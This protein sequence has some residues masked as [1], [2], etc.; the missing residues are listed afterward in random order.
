MIGFALISNCKPLLAL[1]RLSGPFYLI[2][3]SSLVGNTLLMDAQGNEC[4]KNQSS[5]DNGARLRKNSKLNMQSLLVE[6]SCQTQCR[7]VLKYPMI[8]CSALFSLRI[9]NLE[10]I[11]S[12]KSS[13]YIF[14]MMALCIT[15]YV[16]AT[17]L[18][19]SLCEA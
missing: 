2:L 13:F 5:I 18:P 19:T 12:C 14:L 9:S 17:S 1:I 11:S 8:V 16:T 15:S 3:K 10:T 4:H 7:N 6:Y